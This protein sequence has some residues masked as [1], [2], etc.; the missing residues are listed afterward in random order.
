MVPVHLAAA[1]AAQRHVLERLRSDGAI[2]PQSAQALDG[3]SGRQ[4]RQLAR[5]VD[6]GMVRQTNPG[7]YYIDED[8]VAQDESRRMRILV[9]V[10]AILSVLIITAL[11]HGRG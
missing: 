10:L 4:E 11:V 1:R 7:A 8:A 3:L 5:L 9:I 2:S 6:L